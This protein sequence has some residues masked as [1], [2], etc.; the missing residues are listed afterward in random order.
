[1]MLTT[2]ML[3]LGNTSVGV[4]RIE[5]APKIRIKIASTTKVYGRRRARRTIHMTTTPVYDYFREVAHP[6]SATVFIVP[7]LAVC[8][9]YVFLEG[10]EHFRHRVLRAAVFRK[11]EPLAA[12]RTFIGYFVAPDPGGSSRGEVVP[13]LQ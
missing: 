12:R 4:R 7:F 11:H 3:I 9:I 8:F 1:M 6:L 5:T 13:S 2:G 10:R